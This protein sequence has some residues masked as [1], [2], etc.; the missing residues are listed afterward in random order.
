V[1]AGQTASFAL[2]KFKRSQLRKGMVMVNP[3]LEPK[4]CWEFEGDILILHHPTTISVKYQAMVHVGSVRQTATIVSMSKDHLRTGD[5]AV[6]RFRF[7]KGPEYLRPDVRL[8]FREGRTKAVG[9]VTR[10]IAQAV[11]PVGAARQPRTAPSSSKRETGQGSGQGLPPPQRPQNEP[12]KPSKRNRRGRGNAAA[13]KAEACTVAVG[14]A[15]AETGCTASVKL[16]SKL[17]PTS[18]STV[19]VTNQADSTNRVEFIPLVSQS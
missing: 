9:T 3:V 5:K 17:S 10:T 16:E 1:K 11:V 15:K 8:V 7:I 6:V 14:I 4:A 2:K 13:S 19:E 12:Q 18:L